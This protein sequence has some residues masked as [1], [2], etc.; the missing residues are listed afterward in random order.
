MFAIWKI[1]PAT[2]SNDKQN[3]WCFISYVLRADFHLQ[4]TAL[5]IGVRGAGTLL[6]IVENGQLLDSG[7]ALGLLPCSQLD[8][9]C[10]KILM[11]TRL[12]LVK[13]L[14][15]ETLLK[16]IFTSLEIIQPYCN[17]YT[18]IVVYTEFSTAEWTDTICSKK[19][20]MFHTLCY[21]TPQRTC[22]TQYVLLQSS[23]EVLPVPS[24][25]QWEGS[26]HDVQL[27]TPSR[28]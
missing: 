27:P 23:C 10:V 2:Y 22:L 16:S 8:I 12:N 28:L 5:S 6:L 13:P 1:P 19:I 15:H 17:Y 21:G 24:V 9:W 4:M 7:L 14:H 3:P 18:W 20:S 25:P 11:T 26:P